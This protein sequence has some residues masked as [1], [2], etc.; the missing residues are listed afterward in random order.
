MKIRI[1]IDE[2][3]IRLFLTAETQLDKSVLAILGQLDMAE[4]SSSTI[5]S[6]EPWYEQDLVLTL[7]PAPVPIRQV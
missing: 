5:T 7:P 1:A 3:A 4:R 2:S 6:F